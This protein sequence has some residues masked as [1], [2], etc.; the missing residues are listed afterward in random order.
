MEARSN[1]G[2]NEGRLIR[3]SLASTSCLINARGRAEIRCLAAG[4]VRGGRRRRL[5]LLV[6]LGH[7]F[8]GRLVVGVDAQQLSQTALMASIIIHGAG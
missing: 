8:Q 7:R 5:G 3:C 6:E 1:R 4:Q 2:Q